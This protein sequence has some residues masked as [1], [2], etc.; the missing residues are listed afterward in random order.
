MKAMRHHFYLELIRQKCLR[1]FRVGLKGA[2]YGTSK[3]LL[4]L[5]FCEALLVI[6]Q[7]NKFMRNAK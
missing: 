3:F 4:A 5:C 1:T 6:V 7:V 2:F